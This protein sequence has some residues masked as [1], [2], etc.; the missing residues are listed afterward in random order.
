MTTKK[1]AQAKRPCKKKLRGGARSSNAQRHAAARRAAINPMHLRPH[2]R[3]IAENAIQARE[4]EENAQHRA[5]QAAV[6]GEEFPDS[7]LI[8]RQIDRR[9]NSESRTSTNERHEAV[10]REANR[11]VNRP[12]VGEHARRIVHGSLRTLEDRANARHRAVQDVINHENFPGAEGVKH[13]VDYLLKNEYLRNHR[14][15]DPLYERRRKLYDDLAKAR[16]GVGQFVNDLEESVEGWRDQARPKLRRFA[17]DTYENAKTVQNGIKYAK[18]SIKDGI[19]KGVK[20]VADFAGKTFDKWNRDQAEA[21]R[22]WKREQ[23]VA[24]RRQAEKER[25]DRARAEAEKRQKAAERQRAA[26][27]RRREMEADR[28]YAAHRRR[29]PVESPED[30]ALLADMA[31]R[32]ALRPADD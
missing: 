14:T 22:K 12:N 3:R 6:N 15:H 17:S 7:D 24:R 29:R 8:R 32:G 9:L 5:A 31:S 11:R 1:K 10:R 18:D 26:A 13:R 21:Y 27:E 28:L 20:S 4:N 23:E 19:V 25:A 16:A 2:V 30:I